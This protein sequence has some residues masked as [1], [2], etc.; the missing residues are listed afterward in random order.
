MTKL[1]DFFSEVRRARGVSANLRSFLRLTLDLLLYRRPFLDL[2]PRRYRNRERTIKLR[3]DVI[4][5]YRLNKGDIWSLREVWLWECYRFP[6]DVPVHRIL[7]LGANI[8]LASLWLTTQY[9]ATSVVAVEPALDNAKLARRNL[10]QNRIRNV[11][12]DAAAGSRDGSIGFIS[13]PDSNLGM[14]DY[15]ASGPVQLVSMKTVLQK[16]CNGEQIDLL[17]MDIEGGEHD[18]LSSNLEWLQRVNAIIVEFHPGKNGYSG[19]IDTLQREGF[20]YLPADS[21][22][23]N[24]MD[25]FV[26]GPAQ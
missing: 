15:A 22:F 10:E 4:V 16:Y 12:I 23:A 25:S 18:L 14:A 7:D 20:R 13:N 11:V 9:R 19:L 26:R 2:I 1:I 6:A 17:K 21:V 8:G 3:G 24:N 5:T